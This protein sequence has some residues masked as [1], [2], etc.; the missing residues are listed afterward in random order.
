MASDEEAQEAV[1]IAWEEGYAAGRAEASADRERLARLEYELLIE[2]KNCRYCG[3]LKTIAGYPCGRCVRLSAALAAQSGADREW[4]QDQQ[5]WVEQL[6]LAAEACLFNP[7]FH[8]DACQRC[9]ELIV[10]LQRA[11]AAQPGA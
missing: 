6:A 2:L 8:H 3:G 1:D 5:A 4:M 10:L 7:G 11:L 9:S